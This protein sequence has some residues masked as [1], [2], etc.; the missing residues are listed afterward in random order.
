MPQVELLVDHVLEDGRFVVINN[1]SGDVPIG[2][3]F[4][5]L[6]SRFG[7]R[8]GDSWR[9]E[10]LAPLEPVSL[11]LVEVESWRQLLEQIPKGHNA[12]VRLKG[13]GA[14]LLERHISSRQ[15]SV[16]VFLAANQD[17]AT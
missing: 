16:Y 17:A 2:T 14:A 5:T 15:K 8:E 3:T 10:P 6:Q 1:S 12:A 7:V 13:E 11:E 9:E 4:T